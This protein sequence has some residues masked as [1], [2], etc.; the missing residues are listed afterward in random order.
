MDS[1][2]ELKLQVIDLR[3]AFALLNDQ[4]LTL[5]QRLELI[6]KRLQL[7][8]EPSGHESGRGSICT[9]TKAREE[10]LSKLVLRTPGTELCIDSLQLEVDAM[11]AQIRKEMSNIPRLE[12]GGGHGDGELE[13]LQRA[14]RASTADLHGASSAAEGKPLEA[15]RP[16]KAEVTVEEAALEEDAAAALSAKFDRHS[17]GSQETGGG[18]LEYLVSELRQAL[19]SELVHLSF[20]ELP[21]VTSGALLH[22]CTIITE[23]VCRPISN[24]EYAADLLCLC[25]TSA[26][27]VSSFLP[28]LIQRVC[29]FI[30]I[31]GYI[32]HRLGDKKCHKQAAIRLG[33][34]VLHLPAIKLSKWLIPLN[35]A[36]AAVLQHAGHPAETKRHH[37]FA[38]LSPDSPLSVQIN[39]MVTE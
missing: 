39:F 9:D 17:E 34:Y 15:K 2:S 32:Y 35:K 27:R 16:Q 38:Q 25:S 19:S 11:V 21:A 5:E 12:A 18:V 36:V 22:P 26:A 28:E 7:V 1:L 8:D 6:S 24:P 29:G 13:R 10:S 33:V 14:R 31:K 3:L 30:R 20:D 37:L 23:G 4:V